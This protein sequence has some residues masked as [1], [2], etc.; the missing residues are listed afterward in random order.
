MKVKRLLSGFLTPLLISTTVLQGAIPTTVSAASINYVSN[1]APLV[2]TRFITL[3]LGSVNANG[4]LL[5]QLQLQR[6]GLTGNSEAI[7]PELGSNSAWLGGNAPDSDWE[8]PAYYVKGLVSLAYTLNDAGLKQK[9]QKW[10]DWSLKS[11]KADGSF[12]PSTNNDWWPRMPMLNAIMDYYEATNDSRVIP[13]MTNYFHY[14]ANNLGN[15]PLSSWGSA[16]AADNVDAILW[17]Y[18]RTGDSFLLNLTDSI[19]NQVYNYSEIFTNNTFLTSFPQ[20][21][22]PKHN[23]NV[24]EAYKYP[25]VFYQRTNSAVDRDAFMAGYNNLYPYHTQITGM[26]S[27]TEFLSGNSS[28]QGVELCSTVERMLCDEIATRILGDARIGDQLEKIAFNQLPGALDENIH[29]LQYYTLPNQVQSI[30]GGNGYA[31]DYGNGVVPGPYSGYPCCCF[32]L[33]MGWP[34]YVQNSWM[35]TVDN[36]LAVT[37][38][39]PTKV[40]AKVGNGVNVSFTEATNYPFEE[41]MRF[42]FNAS[43]TVAFPLE[44]RIPTWCSKPVVKVNGIIQSGVAPGTYYK[45]NRTWNNGDVVTLDVPM[46]IK[47][48]TWTNNS[49]GIERGPLVYSLKVGE[50]WVKANNYNF[51]NTDF[52]EYQVHP[53]TAWN[54]GLNIDRNNP[55]ASIT[56]QKGVMPTNPFIPATTPVTLKVN[57]QQIPAWGL[58][59]NGIHASEPPVSPVASSQPVQQVTLIPFGAERLRV[60]YLPV[61]GKPSGPSTSFADNFPTNGPN[62]WVNFGGG[63]QQQ[64]G[65]Y[66]SESYNIGGVKSVATTTNFSDFTYEVNVNIQNGG[67]EA[68]EIFRVSNPANGANAYNGYYAGISTNGQVVLGKSSNNWT[69]LGS[70]AMQINIGKAYHMKVITKGSNIQVFVEDMITPKI[71]VNDSSYTSGSIGLRQYCGS[72]TGDPSGQTVIFDSVTVTTVAT[73]YFM[74]INKNSGKALDLIAG[75]TSNGARINQWTYDYN[76]GNQ[77]WSILPVENGHFKIISYVNGKAMC[78]ADASLNDGAQLH[79]WDYTGVGTDQQ[80]DFIEAG[81]GWYKIKNVYSGKILEVL[82]A[83]TT[84]DAKVQQGADNG[85]ASQLWR[86]QPWGDYNIKADSGKYLCIQNKGSTNGSKIIQYDYEDNPWFKWRF[87]NVGDGWSKVSSLNALTR[88]ISVSNGSTTPGAYLHLWDY[89]TSNIGDQKVRIVPR[90]DGKFKFFFAHDGQSFD[91]PGGQTGNNIPVEQNTPNQVSWQ[92]FTLE[93]VQ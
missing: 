71:N 85:S 63:W 53:T 22:M 77:R 3:P 39:G 4:W 66:Y 65:K 75:D 7:Y 2:N 38:Y 87:E 61:I 15:R 55:E 83:A 8:R 84:N 27:G 19:K 91:I 69:Q 57:A 48:S 54:Y 90:T 13:F 64:N 1:R 18:N 89:N 68:G 35:G 74:M 28:T 25:P 70:T 17:L 60:T 73:P 16:R 44:L 36:G 79:N 32:N 86:L 14:E 62:K 11:Q 88:V 10:I 40:N 30:I 41:Q 76:G 50:S 29:Q 82:N 45:I 5:T 78:I 56:V 93:R 52:S 37:A 59:I 42:T 80:W 21:F 6:D 33:H 20:D 67:T 34:K 92:E 31:Q 49:V 47:T 24:S 58:D 72:G 23:V 81:N 43:Q 12:G 26:N 9:A 51:N 46:S